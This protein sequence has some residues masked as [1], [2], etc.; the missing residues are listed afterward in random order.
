MILKRRIYAML[1]LLMMGSASLLAQSSDPFGELDPGAFYGN[2]SM[3]AQVVLGN[4]TLKDD[5][6][7]AVYCGNKLRGKS[8]P[9]TKDAGFFYL[10]VYGN[11][12][13]EQL[14]VKVYTQGRVIE[15]APDGLVYEHN[16]IK[17]SY[18]NPVVIDLPVPVVTT[19]SQE[20]W[21]TTCLPF[22]AEVPAGVTVWNVTG[23]A[24]GQVVMSESQGKILPKD[25]PALLQCQGQA[26][27][28]WLA[29]VAD[30]DVAADG[31]ILVGTTEP[32]SVAANSV[33]TL[34]HAVETGAIGFWRYT[35]TTV[36]ANCAYI[37][38]AP[39]GTRGFALFDDGATAVS[40]VESPV[41]PTETYDLQGRRVSGQRSLWKKNGK[42]QII[43]IR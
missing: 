15:T 2:M 25:T 6:V 27:Y 17:G 8:A 3:T 41:Q 42:G 29:R 10:T 35:G 22:N 36:P 14:H 7:L 18:Q 20:G 34:G 37:A 39:A 16:G 30:G 33:M 23:T 26:S 19:P 43:V 32:T 9:S 13:G 11:N 1:A 28:E 31:S 21:A 40:R 12:S 4:E 38:N 24:G 5:V